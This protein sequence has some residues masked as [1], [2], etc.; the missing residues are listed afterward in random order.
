VVRTPLGSIP[1][2]K[3]DDM[4]N[5]IRIRLTVAFI[6]LAIG[7]L[8]LVG[9]IL[10]R[11][12]FTTQEQQALNLQREVARRVV[13]EVTA[14]FEE[15]ENELRLVSKAQVWPGLGQN[16]HYHILTL[17]MS[18]DIFEGLVLLDSQGQE[19]IHLSRL[20]H[21]STDLG[22]HTEADEFVIPQTSGQVYYSPIRFEETT[23]E[24]LMTIAVPLLDVR[25]G[26]VDGVL[27]SETRIKKVW[28]LIAGMKVSPGQSVY[29]VD[30]QGKVV[31]HRNPSVVL[32]DTR[33]DVPNRDGIQPGLIG[34]GVV[35]AIETARFGEQEFNV[36]AEQAISEA[37]APAINSMYV[38]VATIVV[39]L[40][41]ASSL[42][43]LIVRQ[44]VRPVE[45]L[46]ATAQAI[47]TGDLSQQVEVTGRD[48][49]GQLAAAFNRMLAQL[50]DLFDSLEQRIAE[51]KQAEEGQR[52]ALAE[53]L[54]AKQALQESEARLREVV[55]HM[56]VL[57]D[58]FDENGTAL[59]WNKEC[60]RVTGYSA[61]EIVDNPKSLELICPD[62]EYRVWV[63]EQLQELGNYY[64]DWE[65]DVQCK[66]GETRTIAWSNISRDHPIPGWW[67]WGIGVDVT[68]RKWAEEALR[69]SEERYRTVSELTSDSAYA[70]R[71]NS[72][73]TLILEWMTE[74]ATRMLGY[75]HADL[76]GP[77]AWIQ[78]AHP[79]DIPMIQ[80][81]VQLLLSCQPVTFEVRLVAKN[82]E[83]HWVRDYVRPDWD[84][85]EGRVIRIVGAFQNITERK[86]AEEALR[87]SEERFRQ[88][89]E[90]LQ[91]VAYRRNLQTDTY[92]YMSP[93]QL[94]I[95]GYTA[96]EI[97]SMPAAWVLDRIHPDD[98]DH[99]ARALEE[100]VTGGQR[101]CHLEYRFKCKDGQ[102]R[103]MNDLFTVVRDAQGRPLYR[104]GTVRDITEHKQ[105]EVALHESEQ[106]FRTLAEASFEG[107]ALTER[108]VFVDLNDQLANMLGYA[109]SELIGQPVMEAVAPES[110]DLVAEAIRSGRLEPYEHLA[111]RKDGT[112]FPVEA[113]ARAT[114]MA[115]RQLRVSAI[116]DITERKQAEEAL[117][118]SEEK[119]RSVIENAN[120]G[121]LVIQDA[122]QVFY[123]SKMYD[124]LGYTEEEYSNTDFM[125][126]IHPE[127]RPYAV[128]RIRQRLMGVAMDPVMAEMRVLAQSEDIKWIETNSAVIQWEGRPAVQAFV[129]DITE[130]KQAENALRDAE[131]EKGAILDS[132]LEHVIY[133]DREHRILWPN[134]AACES[135]GMTREELVGRYCYEIWPRRHE[136]CEDCP[137]ALAIATGQRQEIEK[138][139]PD[140]RAWFI[141]GYPVR[142]ANGEIVGAIEVTQDI[143]ERRQAQKE[144]E[145]LLA[146]V[147]EQAQ[148]VQQIMDTVPEG[149]LL[150]DAEKRVMLANP[151]AEGD[152]AVLADAKGGD[153]LTHLGDRPLAELLSSPPQGLWHEVKTDSRTFE[154][155]AR[156]IKVDPSPS[157]TRPDWLDPVEPVEGWVLVI[158]DVTQER[159]IEQRAQQ[160][161]RLAAIGQL[162]AGIAHDFNNIMAVIVLYTQMGLR[163]P[164]L[165]PE[166]RRR[167]ETVTQQAKRATDLIQQI[168][169]FSRRAVL[170]RRPMDLVPFLKEQ[171]RLLKRTLPEHITIDLHYGPDEYTVNA[172]PTRMQQVVMNLAVNARD[173]MPTGGALHIG[174]TRL[175]VKAHKEA[176][177]PELSPG[178]WVQMTV[179]DTGTGIPA[180]V[181]P[182]IFEPF[183][184]TKAPLG[185]GLGLAQV[186]GIVKQHEGE[187]GV[188]TKPGQGTTFT[189]YLPAL[190]VA[191]SQT[192]PEEASLFP[193]GQG[194]TILVVEDDAVTRQALSECL[195]LLNYQVLTAANG[196]QALTI[197]E[198]HAEVAA[199]LS[200]VVMPEMGGMALLEALHQRGL[201]VP[202]LLLTGH[203]MERDVE[204]L[205]AQGLSAWLL[206]PPS[207]EQLAQAMSETLTK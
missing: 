37:L 88:V 51:R 91:D 42:G 100:S 184:T 156:P 35:L 197:L 97:L 27:I 61:D 64:R 52:Q 50:R 123:N 25:T 116:R 192:P 132:Q 99:V 158:R 150:L 137:I 145:Q 177:L 198:Q 189:L 147:Q 15:R 9:V 30:A 72:D 193:K 105:A 174:L 179:A 146:Q 154:V 60:E 157:R 178:D 7:P 48:E 139:T 170:E 120:I 159:E 134:R 29:I 55:E 21:F 58:A 149:M 68:E 183:F 69:E 31:A 47:S 23:G 190:P 101:H 207:L 140:G 102:Y 46:T 148:R 133:Q 108:G 75:P 22:H 5:S 76:S 129:I 1:L 121:I 95:S 59:F 80:E 41:A 122:Q 176:P 180:G 92:D 28:N 4:R 36:V 78:A 40:V 38:I 203:P 104:I 111:L 32:R 86:R 202:V 65:L 57:F 117:R 136:R 13:T 54:Q 98:L 127:D 194:Q 43:F 94:H 173:A 181:L 2:G 162:A 33:F 34:S 200:D 141:R 143:T 167:L 142:D 49:I 165:P 83:V 161:E 199:V 151:V 166:T 24:P 107:I 45:S 84:E 79:E 19:Q 66:N 11:Q 172:D 169:D 85:A 63:L 8:L 114:Q 3:V 74:A 186:H 171:L 106:R 103:W 82:G 125:S 12:S 70:Y 155:I 20:A 10:A 201:E 18:Q 53:A 135:V 138:T 67:S 26:L 124:M 77:D 62:P 109:R 87:E 56:P 164:S 96:E 144:R 163:T 73:G 195:T 113:R 110:R 128:D 160:Q 175:H 17:L 168:L 152:L 44:I 206:K 81:Q 93:A 188:T 115:G 39:A 16:K 90:S 182:H 205:Q 131:A 196:R 119:Y 89:L 6:G 204:E 185:S 191:E 153:I 126:L 187:V 130:R 118:E 14:F 71:V 112:A